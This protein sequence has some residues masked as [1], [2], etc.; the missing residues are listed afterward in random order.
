M[1]SPEENAVSLCLTEYKIITIRA[2]FKISIALFS[3]YS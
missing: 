2:T 1:N 3:N